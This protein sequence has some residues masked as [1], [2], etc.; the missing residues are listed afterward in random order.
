MILHARL[1]VT[2]AGQTFQLLNFPDLLGMVVRVHRVKLQVEA[3]SEASTIGSL[4]A[5]NIGPGFTFQTTEPW[6]AW[7]QL[8]T[9]PASA[10]PAPEQVYDEPYE[11]I[12]RQRWVVINAAG[13]IT[14]RLSAVY[15]LR[16]EPS[17]TLWT[18]LRAKTSFATG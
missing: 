17:Q 2:G 4:I 7:N 14:V 5:H 16:K 15:S 18:A 10:S 3:F 6:K 13:N 8:F 1:T 12:G 9:F 11:L